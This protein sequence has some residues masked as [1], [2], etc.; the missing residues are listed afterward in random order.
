MICLL[1]MTC[2]YV[3]FG[4]FSDSE[5]F[6]LTPI[7][8]RVNKHNKDNSAEAREAVWS[9]CE[10]NLLIVAAEE[11]ITVELIQQAY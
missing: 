8:P 2:I 11:F 5:S 1:Y 6:P 4:Y 10:F 7:V 9:L 3:P